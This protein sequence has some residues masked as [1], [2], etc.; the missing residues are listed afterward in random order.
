M[1]QNSI[2]LVLLY[3]PLLENSQNLNSADGDATTVQLRLGAAA[4]S[5]DSL[6]SRSDLGPSLEN[7]RSAA[8]AH[9]I[10]PSGGV[11]PVQSPTISAVP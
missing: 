4:L 11:G 9:N 8:A 3:C 5:E 7:A 10:A 6:I 1:G 2:Y